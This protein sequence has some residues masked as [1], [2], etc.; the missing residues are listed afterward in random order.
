ML[1]SLVRV[2]RRV[3]WG[4]DKPARDPL[5]HGGIPPHAIGRQSARTED[6]PRQSGRPTGRGSRVVEGSSSARR[7]GGPR[8]APKRPRP[9]P[10][11]RSG[12]YLDQTASRRLRAGPGLSRGKC[13]P[14]RPGD[15][16]APAPM[17]G[18]KG[19]T[20]RPDVRRLNSTGRKLR[21]HPFTSKRFH[22][23]LNSLFK[24]LFN[25]PSRYLSAIGLVA[26]FSLRWSLP[27]ALGCIPKQPDSEDARGTRGPRRR[28]LTPALGGAPIRRTRAQAPARDGRP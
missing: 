24:V 9:P 20:R 23:L 3:G 27:P 16:G 15:D 28:G 8:H 4:A 7:R 10:R 12:S 14:V 21:S 26:V 2:S 1:D 17:K 13:A 22:V 18:S 25:F 6:S 19:N 11:G 5:R